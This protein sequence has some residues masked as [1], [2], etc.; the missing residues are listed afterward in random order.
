MWVIVG[1]LATT[2][3]WENLSEFYLNIRKVNKTIALGMLN[4]SIKLAVE[5][6]Y[7]QMYQLKP[8]IYH[9]VNVYS[10]VRKYEINE[11]IL[12]LAFLH[13]TLEDTKITKE[14]LSEISS[15]MPEYV[16]CLTKVNLSS[17][18][19]NCSKYYETAIVKMAD[20]IVNVRECVMFGNR[21]QFYKYYKQRKK[22]RVIYPKLSIKMILTLEILY[23]RGLINIFHILPY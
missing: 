5:K 7:G 19:N 1:Q 3:H 8:Y 9:L 17:Y 2:L 10:E 16:I 15:M 6:H 12:S 14:E 18:F 11:E 23:L 21:K 4:K 22:F 20:R 13:D